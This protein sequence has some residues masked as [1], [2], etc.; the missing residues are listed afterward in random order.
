LPV[1]GTKNNSEL[2]KPQI[3][4]TVMNQDGLSSSLTAPNGSSQRALIGEVL[5]AEYMNITLQ[6]VHIHGTGTPLGD[7]IEINALSDVMDCKKARKLIPLNLSAIKSSLGHAEVAAGMISIISLISELELS[8]KNYILHLRSINEH[9]VKR[10][11]IVKLIIT[12]E[13]SP[14]SYVF[15]DIEKRA[16]IKSIGSSCFAFQGTNT[17]VLVLGKKIDEFE[18]IFPNK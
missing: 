4:K 6:G 3:G 13:K 18:C 8:E 12:R 14:H 7:P 10:G 5:R 15:E 1:S 16:H 17:H 9:L 2:V 11:R